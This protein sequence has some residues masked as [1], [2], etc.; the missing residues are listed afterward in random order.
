MGS[1]FNATTMGLLPEVSSNTSIFGVNWLINTVLVFICM[2]IITRD[3]ELWKIMF[4][5]MTLGW[6]IIG[7]EA[8]LIMMVAGS[9]V[10]LI[11]TV[12]LQILGNI[13]EAIPMPDVTKR[14]A[15]QNIAEIQETTSQ[16]PVIGPETL[17]EYTARLQ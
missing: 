7:V 15:K 12:S 17:E 6:H 11:N 3:V 8:S 9:I 1:I 14:Q 5:P 16:I 10:F 2:A 4:F 13:I